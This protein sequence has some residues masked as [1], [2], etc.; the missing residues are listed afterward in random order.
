MQGI[1]LLA[2]AIT[3]QDP[4]PLVLEQVV[5]TSAGLNTPVGLAAQVGDSRLFI[6]EIG[7]L[8]KILRGTQLDAAPFADVSPWIE[9]TALTGLRAMAF[10]PDHAVNGQV[11]FWVDAPDGSGGVDAVLGR[12]TL[13]PASVDRVD[14]ASWTE[15]LRAPQEGRGHGGGALHFGP[16]GM[17]HAA[18]GDGGLA[19]DPS[20]NAQDPMSLMG[21]VLR[22]DVDGGTPYGIPPDNP[23][24]STPGVRPE[25]LHLGLRH[26]W[27]WSFDSATGD[28]WVADVGQAEREEVTFIRA[29]QRGFNLGWSRTEGNLCFASGACG[30]GVDPCGSGAYLAPL[31]EYDHSL[32]CSITGGFV[33]RGTEVPFLFGTYLYG[34]FCNG[35]MGYLRTN[36]VALTA[37]GDFDVRTVPASASFTSPVA[38]GEGGDGE[39]YVI[40]FAGAEI[41]RVAGSCGAETVCTGAPNAVGPGATLRASGSTSVVA[42]DLA[43]R[44][45]G[46]PPS[47]SAILF[48]GGDTASVPA[49][50]GTRCVGP[51]SAGLFRATV[52]FANASGEL[53]LPLDLT[54]SPFSAGASRI[55]AGST[56]YFQAWYR[57]VGGPLGA[58][59]NLTSAASVLFCP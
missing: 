3:P 42:N 49:G 32:G 24:A 19:G 36:G 22:I 7:G 41:Y 9:P 16:D 33:Y 23:F 11:F 38:F 52:A 54:T 43:F 27:K 59:F 10:H 47:T 8:V 34:D 44:V 37:S 12:M 53:Q 18:L 57:D 31:H 50:N 14:P 21:T 35:R 20:C 17:L 6:T 55:D 28:L 56:W 48:Y 1:L 45:S 40:D 39:L 4:V 46:L 58:T 29:L 26:P 13:D 15:I 5:P 30:P 2:L 25:I 51:G